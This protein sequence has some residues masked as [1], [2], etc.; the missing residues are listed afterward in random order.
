MFGDFDQIRLKPACSDTETNKSKETAHIETRDVS[1]FQELTTI[2][3]TRQ[4]ESA[5]VSLYR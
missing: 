4:R 2:A 1:P 3:Q 5:D